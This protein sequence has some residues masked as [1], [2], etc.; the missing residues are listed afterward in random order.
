MCNPL[1][2]SPQ[3]AAAPDSGEDETNVTQVEA[4]MTLMKAVKK[5]TNAVERLQITKLSECRFINTRKTIALTVT[6]VESM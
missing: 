3:A 6:N 4:I 2:T 1:K 5:L